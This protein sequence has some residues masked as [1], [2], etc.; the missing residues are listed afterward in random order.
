MASC[1]ELYFTVRGKGG[2]GAMPHKVIDPVVIASQIVL[3]LQQVVSRGMDIMNPTVLSI[4]KVEAN[5]ATN[6]IP[7][8]V[9]MAGTFRTMNEEWRAEAHQKIISIAEGIAK[10]SGGDCEVEIK[11]G[12]PCLVNNPEATDK[13]KLA[14]IE[15]LGEENVVD[16]PI[17]MTAEDFSYYSQYMPST[18]YRLGVN[19]EAEGIV[20]PV[21]TAQFN[22]DEKALNTGMGLMA[23]LVLKMMNHEG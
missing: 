20:H 8:L 16:L 2:H 17:R 1:D 9:K 13:C 14:A 15:Y 6:I 11:K 18:F 7:D 10:S 19:N 4:G 22:I 21:H 5:G 3:G 23:W 12:Y